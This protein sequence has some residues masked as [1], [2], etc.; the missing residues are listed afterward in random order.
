MIFDIFNTLDG[1]TEL[2][3]LS[4]KLGLKNNDLG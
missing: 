4:I 1:I 2:S 3:S